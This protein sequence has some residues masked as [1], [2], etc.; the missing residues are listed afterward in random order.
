MRRFYQTE[1]QNIQFVSFA[2]LSYFKLANA[3]F[4]SAF[5]KKFF[6]QYSSYDSLPASWQ[7]QKKMWA[8]CIASSTYFGGKVLSVGC[9]LGYVEQH[10]LTLRPDI[11]LY[12]TEITQ[13]SLKW[14][15][16]IFHADRL[17]TGYIPDCLPKNELYD[18]IYCGTIDYA[19]TNSEWV[20]MLISLRARLN[21]NG[22]IL[23]MTASLLLEQDQPKGLR[24]WLANC[25]A[26]VKILV[27]HLLGHEKVQFWGWMRTEREYVS[28]FT[29]IGLRLLS[30]SPLGDNPSCKLFILES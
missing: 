10:L 23:I 11:D 9:G 7:A 27:R 29:S 1:W 19:M 13:S 26:N 22:K 17:Y 6:E 21:A 5:Y 4:Y 3:A 18:I 14:L 12:C 16:K 15:T 8:E 20:A 24:G 28:T 2:D 25:K 30:S